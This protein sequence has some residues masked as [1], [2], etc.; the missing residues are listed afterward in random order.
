MPS[1]RTTV[2]TIASVVWL[3]VAVY[4]L[5]RD[6]TATGKMSPNEWGDFLAGCFAP[7]AFLWLVLG[8]LQQGDELRLSTDALRLQA[9]ELRNSVEQQR[10][11]VEVSRQQVQSEREALVYERTLREDLSS[12][13]FRVEGG[14]GAFR[15]DGQSSY[16]VTFINTGHDAT[17]FYSEVQLPDGFRQSL[18]NQALFNKGAQYSTHITMPMRFPRVQGKLILR[19]VDG[20]GR[21]TEQ[22][23][24][25]TRTDE[26]DHSGLKFERIEA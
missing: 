23:F 19:F 14:G 3:A 6:P 26:S 18:L 4:L 2:G 1:R 8:Y 17:A 10:E 25:A 5:V 15:G 21:Q 20:L 11:L 7:L 16:N 24:A 12:P 22:T 13:K 9:E